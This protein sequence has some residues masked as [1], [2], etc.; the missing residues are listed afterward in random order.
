MAS[1]FIAVVALATLAA[2]PTPMTDPLE[3]V[4]RLRIYFGH[5]SVGGNLVE[6]VTRLAGKRLTVTEVRSLTPSTLAA[7][8]LAH[9]LIGSNEAPLTKIA[10]FERALDELNGQVDVALFKFCYVDFTATTDVDALFTAYAQ[11]LTRLKG[12][13]PKVTFATVTT[14]LSVVQSGVKAWVKQRLGQHPWGEQENRTR[15]AFNEKLRAAFGGPALFDLARLESTR[16]DGTRETY[17]VEGATVPKLRD[18]FTDDG[19]HLNPKG[20]RAAAQAFVAFLG[21]QRPAP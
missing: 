16:D 9:Q 2:E 1:S 12:K 10:A 18:D 8:A 6:G 17:Q 20:A 4:A 19:G 21:T 3:Q 14:P 5:Q 7:P 13:Y 15:H 11:A